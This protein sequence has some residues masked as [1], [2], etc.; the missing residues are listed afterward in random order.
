MVDSVRSDRA[1]EPWCTRFKEC[2]S[3][4]RV[5]PATAVR[6]SEWM[7]VQQRLQFR[8]LGVGEV[9]APVEILSAPIDNSRFEML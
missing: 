6:A 5:D 4:S 3:T 7:L 2:R 8:P 9:P 1:G